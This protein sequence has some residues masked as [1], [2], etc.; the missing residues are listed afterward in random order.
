MKFPI[1]RMIS[2][3]LPA[4]LLACAAT[5]CGPQDEVNEEDA[6]G[7]AAEYSA[8][9]NNA[10]DPMEAE[11]LNERAETLRET[12]RGSEEAEENVTVTGE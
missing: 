10:T 11:I 5:A 12:S 4:V 8:G 9:A 6:A 1:D 2:R 3:V 7:L